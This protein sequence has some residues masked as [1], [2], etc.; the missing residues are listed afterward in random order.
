MT[1]G[2]TKSFLSFL[3]AIFVCGNFANAQTDAQL[4]DPEFL[5]KQYNDLAAKHNALVEKTRTV[6][7]EK[8]NAPPVEVQSSQSAICEKTAQS[9]SCK[10]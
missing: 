9:A 7:M 3:T 10:E 2:S 4:R 6:V 8:L 5:I 1:R